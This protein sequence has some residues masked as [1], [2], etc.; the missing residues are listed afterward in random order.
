MPL[1]N[2]DSDR[3]FYL[4]VVRLM[5]SVPYAQSLVFG[6]DC[7]YLHRPDILLDLQ[8]FDDR[9]QICSTAAQTRMNMKRRPYLGTTLTRF[10]RTPRLVPRSCIPYIPGLTRHPINVDLAR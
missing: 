4:G 6:T 1:L 3:R 2:R 5:L 10:D 7:A 8:V 9:G